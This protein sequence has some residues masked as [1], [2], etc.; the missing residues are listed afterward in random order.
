M[1]GRLPL[2][3][4][5]PSRILLE[6]VV[7]YAGLFPPAGLE[8]PRAVRNFAHHR[9]S[10]TGWMLGRFVCPAAR[11]T[12]FS[13]AADPL[14][15]R[16]AGAVP[17]LV[18]ATASGNVHADLEHIGAFN[19]RHRVCF[20]ECGARVDAY[21]VK[22]STVEDI[23]ALH[24]MLPPSLHVWF[25]IPHDADV[26]GLIEAVGRTGRFAKIRTGGVVSEAFPA[27][28]QVVRFLRALHTFGVRA[29][30]TAGLHHPLRGSYRL[31]YETEAPSCHMFGFLNVL[32]AAAVMAN[33]GSDAL[34]TLLLEETDPSA[35][36]VHDTH[37]AW[38]GAGGHVAID[39]QTLLLA[40]ERMLVSIGSCSFT[41][42][43]DE[44][45]ALGWI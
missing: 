15:P 36:E 33:G 28:S 43:V 18:S 5:R 29:K 42:P 30:A 39:R 44:S 10:G 8:M 37:V 32:L 31:S 13:T 9:A 34:A 23:V 38:R 1:P 16:D 21:E 6:A 26:E 27:S 4:E 12:E 19:E 24:A 41:E 35:L 45:R 22:V 7:D 17:W 3:T 14:L 2:L 20:E 25:E 40:R 11:L